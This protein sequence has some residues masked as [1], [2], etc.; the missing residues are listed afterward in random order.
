MPPG[1]VDQASPRGLLRLVLR[2]PIL[3]YRL[4]LG[5][6]LGRRFL[7][8]RHTGRNSGKKRVTVVEVL[9]WDSSSDECV[10]ASG[11]GR[12]A[13]WYKNVRSNPDIHYT[14]GVR[15]TKGTANE[16]SIDE[17][18]NELRNYGSRHPKMIRKLARIMLGKEFDAGEP[19]YSELAARVPI[20]RLVPRKASA[21]NAR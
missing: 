1:T 19:F 11:W 9:R 21:G 6:V 2:M 13:Q 12:N 18:E 3:L 17:G 16:L 8:L 5:W 20:L 15:E 4:R 10:I 14:I 7:L